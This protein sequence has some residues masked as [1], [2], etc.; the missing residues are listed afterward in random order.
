[1]VFHV[2]VVFV[3]F[4]RYLSFRHVKPNHFL[5]LHVNVGMC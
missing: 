3:T 1:M 4:F 5:F 2:V